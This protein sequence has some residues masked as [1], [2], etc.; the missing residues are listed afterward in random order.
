[1][2]HSP[3]CMDTID[4]GA[5]FCFAI[6]LFIALLAIKRYILDPKTYIKPLLIS[7]I[8][9]SVSFLGILDLVSAVNIKFI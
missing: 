6:L 5:V 7:F 1:M 2:L 9:S 8:V 3:S 4:F